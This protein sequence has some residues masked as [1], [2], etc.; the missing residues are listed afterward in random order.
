MEEYLVQL[1]KD[2][3]H[4]AK[5]LEDLRSRY[6]QMKQYYDTGGQSMR[7]KF[8]DMTDIDPKDQ[9][10]WWWKIFANS[11]IERFLHGAYGSIQEHLEDATERLLEASEDFAEE[12]ADFDSEFK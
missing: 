8:H 4:L 3:P 12:E 6:L 11:D 1:A 5:Q 7:V 9:N 2:K 10:K